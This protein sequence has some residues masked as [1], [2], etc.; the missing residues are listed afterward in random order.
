[1][2]SPDHDR[3]LVQLA[4]ISAREHTR[5]VLFVDRLLEH[6]PRLRL[7][8]LLMVLLL[9]LLRIVPIV[10][11]VL[12]VVAVLLLLWLILMLRMTIVAAQ[13][14]ANAA[15]LHLRVLFYGSSEQSPI[16]VNREQT[17]HHLVHSIAHQTLAPS[18]G[19]LGRL[20]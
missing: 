16:R 1:M 5:R 3:I 19:A 9:L 12:I 13:E 10:T 15:R 8:L 14:A 18:V 4:A 2:L 17:L 11:L 20:L 7:R 6:M